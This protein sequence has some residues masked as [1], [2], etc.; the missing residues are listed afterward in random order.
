MT[1]SVMYSSHYKSNDSDLS[2][3]ELTLFHLA[4]SQLP[5]PLTPSQP[6]SLLFVSLPFNYLHLQST[7]VSNYFENY[8][9]Y[10]VPTLL[11]P[12]GLYILSDSVAWPL[13]KW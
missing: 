3:L 4:P 10:L 8:S 2:L 12:L 6:P 11:V 7:G 13:K 9:K 1:L 5:T